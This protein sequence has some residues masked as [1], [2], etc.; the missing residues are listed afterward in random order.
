[1]GLPSHLNVRPEV[2]EHAAAGTLRTRPLEGMRHRSADP[3]KKTCGFSINVGIGY[4]GWE[5]AA[6][7]RVAGTVDGEVLGHRVGMGKSNDC[8]ASRSAI[9]QTSQS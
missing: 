3:A 7:G 2:I 8:R 6:A 5:V 4:R 9:W 1:M